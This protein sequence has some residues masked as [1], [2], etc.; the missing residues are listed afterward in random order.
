MIH[1][2]ILLSVCAAMAVPSFALAYGP[3]APVAPKAGDFLP[4]PAKVGGKE[5]MD[6]VGRTAAGGLNNGL[7]LAWDGLGD[8]LDGIDLFPF[9][10]TAPQPVADATANVR[11]A[12]YRALRAD[13]SHLLF[14]VE[15]AGS[16]NITTDAAHTIGGGADISFAMSTGGGS[17][18][19]EWAD[20]GVDIDSVIP[21]REL[22]NLEVWGG[23]LPTSPLAGGSGDITHYSTAGEVGGFSVNHFDVMTGISTGYVTHAAIVTV[24]TSLL[25]IPPTSI[26]IDQNFDVDA[27]MV[28]DVI[29]DGRVFDAVA[30]R[31]PGPVDEI[32]FSI[33]QMPN[34]AGGL[35]ATGSEIFWLDSSGA[36]GFLNQGGH[37]WDKAWAEA[38]LSV[39]FSPPGAEPFRVV[40][41]IDAIEA[42]SVPEPGALGVLL[43]GVGAMLR[44]R[45]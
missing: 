8:T 28:Q 10:P 30:A 26:P 19:G 37:L 7:N 24:V 41:D 21:V 35:Y 44:R 5:I 4:A 22:T 31:G 11:D 33:K 32:L 12:L 27:L 16:A 45:K 15:G 39:T 6:G 23:E 14:S 40:L 25:G 17:G 34:P 42:A 29:G 3:I 20:G 38:N 1:R 2:S 18:L 36:F 13:K 43:I 9:P